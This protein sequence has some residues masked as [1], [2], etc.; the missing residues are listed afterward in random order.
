MQTRCEGKSPVNSG[1]PAQSASNA[2]SVPFHGVIMLFCG[3]IGCTHIY[4]ISISMAQ[5]RGTLYYIFWYKCSLWLIITEMLNNVHFKR[6]ANSWKENFCTLKLLVRHQNLSW[7]KPDVYPVRKLATY[8]KKYLNS[9]FAIIVCTIAVFSSKHGISCNGRWRL[10][11]QICTTAILYAILLSKKLAW[12]HEN[13]CFKIQL[14]TC[15]LTN[16]LQIVFICKFA[17]NTNK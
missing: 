12:W 6:F 11:K 3:F 2:K 9:V 17:P 15:T 14:Q 5:D 1:F 7:F 10:R 16:I 8:L 4:L 13:H